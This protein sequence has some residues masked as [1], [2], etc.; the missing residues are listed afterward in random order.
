M[1]SVLRRA[2]LATLVFGLFVPTSLFAQAQLLVNGV[3]APSGVTVTAGATVAVTVSGASGSAT[4]WVAST[5]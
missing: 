3:A 4:D 2:A 1:V 5:L